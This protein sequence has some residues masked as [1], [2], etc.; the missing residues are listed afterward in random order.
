[1][2]SFIYPLTLVLV[3]S[4]ASCGYESPK[5]KALKAQNDS[6]TAVQ[7]SLERNA[8]EYVYVFDY[9]NKSLD[10]I[11]GKETNQIQSIATKLNDEENAAVNSSI[12][13]FNSLLESNQEEIE[14]LKTQARRNAF[15]V[16]ELQ[17]NVQQLKEE[18]EEVASLLPELKN[19]IEAKNS[20]LNSLNINIQTLT[21][22]LDATKKQLADQLALVAKYEADLFTGYYIIGTKSELRGKDVLTKAGLCKTILFQKEVNNAAFTKI[23]ILEATEIKLPESVKGKVLSA[24]PKSSYRF[25]KQGDDKLIQITNPEKFWSVTKYLVIQ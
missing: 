16:V 9:L 13:K 4:F 21:V 19:E 23:N 14:A 8:K 10:K 22:E 24:H 5:Y 17:R 2:K 1:M 12:T 7:Q 25:T 15:K 11:E 3:L 20:A 18:K 6:I